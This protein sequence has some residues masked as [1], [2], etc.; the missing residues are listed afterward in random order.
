MQNP[1]ASHQLRSPLSVAVLLQ[2]VKLGI[3]SALPTVRH[4]CPLGHPGACLKA[5]N[6]SPF[7][8]SLWKPQSSPQIC[9]S[10]ASRAWCT[11]PSKLFVS[12]LT[13]SIEYSK[14]KQK[15]NHR[16]GPVS[17]ELHAKKEDNEDL[18]QSE[19]FIVTRTNKN[20]ETDLRTQETIDHLQ[21][22][23]QSGYNDDEAVQTVFGKERHGRVRF[24]GRSVTKSS[25]KKDKEKI[26]ELWR[27]EEKFWMQRSGIKWLKW[28]RLQHNLLSCFN[29][30]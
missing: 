16:M 21:N 25:L 28:G 23:K 27:Q 20:R 24:Y 14:S 30:L 17:F 3:S 19:M 11:K 15:W 8:S 7:M 18:S 6:P 4:W 22:L 13:H 29:Y 9:E 1:V 5:S 2:P 10:P 26:K 12:A